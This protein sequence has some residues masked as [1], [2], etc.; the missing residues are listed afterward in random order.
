MEDKSWTLAK[1]K[2]KLIRGEEFSTDNY[3]KIMCKNMICDLVCIYNENC[4]YAHTL[5]EQKIDTVRSVVYDMVKKSDDL[6]HIDLLNDKDL[7]SNLL[8]LTKLCYNCENKIC[9]GGYNC[10]H[11][12]CNKKYVV[13]YTDIVK[14]YCNG[15]CD[16]NHLTKK[17]II[18][19]GAR[20]IKNNKL[21]TY[22]YNKTYNSFK[23]TNKKVNKDKE[24]EIT[25]DSD[26]D[27]Y[28][29][30]LNNDDTDNQNMLNKS[31]FC[32]DL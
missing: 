11:G 26:D 6:S 15:N 32:I 21:K 22:S 4:L 19:Y 9:N 13:C 14:G 18:P 17:G 25:T 2:T 30:I 23:D 27:T 5:E 12:A 8:I 24:K 31:I 1:T 20:L 7:Y 3:K 28:D 29:D 16:K 10:K